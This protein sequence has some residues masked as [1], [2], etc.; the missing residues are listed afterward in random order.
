[1]SATRTITAVTETEMLVEVV[2]KKGA[3][4]GFGKLQEID[5]AG[6]TAMEKS[7]DEAIFTTQGTIVKF[8][9]LNLPA[10][11]DLKVVYKLRGNGPAR[12]R[13]HS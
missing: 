11:S 8:V 5:P 6:F 9:W 4:R 10:K 2:V 3:I 13:L 7:S 12:G 1:M